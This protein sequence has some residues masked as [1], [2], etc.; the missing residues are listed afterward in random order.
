LVA[1]ATWLLLLLRTQ[2]LTTA[3]VLTILLAA[4][5]AG[6]ILTVRLSGLPADIA[7]LMERLRSR[8]WRDPMVVFQEGLARLPLTLVSGARDHVWAHNELV[9]LLSERDLTALL[10]QIEPSLLETLASDEYSQVVSAY[11][12]RLRHAS[13]VRVQ[14]RSSIGVPDGTARF[15]FP[16]WPT[17]P[18][19]VSRYDIANHDGGTVRDAVA[20]L[21]SASAVRPAVDRPVPAESDTASPIALGMTTELTATQHEAVDAAANK[22]VPT[23]FLHTSGSRSSTRMSSAI[24]GR[25]PRVD[26]VLPDVGT[27]SRR[28]ARFSYVDGR[29][30]VECLGRNG[31]LLNGREVSLRQVVNDED[32]LTWGR[33]TSALT[34]Q[35]Q[36]TVR[37]QLAE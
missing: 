12:A 28:H 23:L 25:D 27:V 13:P 26:L 6:V 4:V 37:H 21:G 11:G 14:I 18:P 2:S 7:P 34:S 16:G 5:L 31:L 35:V 3:T 9:M 19:S 30:C 17:A 8:P 1:A 20:D 32:T 10:R 24:A 15:R 36:L 33:S 22:I 29:W